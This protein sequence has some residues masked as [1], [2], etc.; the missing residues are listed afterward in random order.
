[1]VEKASKKQPAEPR[2]KLWEVSPLTVREEV[3]QAV[4]RAVATPEKTSLDTELK[5]MKL[6]Q[7]RKLQEDHEMNQLKVIVEEER[8]NVAE[9]TGRRK[10]LEAQKR[11]AG[12]Q[13]QQADT[14]QPPVGFTM[15]DVVELSKLPPDQKAD[16]FKVLMMMKPSG[17]DNGY[18]ILPLLLSSYGQQNPKAGIEEMLAFARAI[19]EAAKNMVNQNNQPPMSND[20]IDKVITL[21]KE[22]KQNQPAPQPGI[23]D[24]IFGNETTY[25]RIKD[26]FGGGKHDAEASANSS[27][28]KL[29]IE[30]QFEIDSR[31]LDQE[32]ELKKAEID[33]EM[34]KADAFGNGVIRLVKAAGT[35]LAQGEAEVDQA[36]S[37]EETRRT[38][39][40]QDTRA[41]GINQIPCP[42]PGCG[43]MIVVQNPKPGQDIKCAKCGSI[44]EWQPNNNDNSNNSQED[45]TGG[46][47]A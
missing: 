19:N 35:A 16:A 14:S 37:P 21:A 41:L 4:D 30:K 40:S 28:E 18:G 29:R 15:A 8:I 3:N 6:D 31:K 43:A 2:K 1:M 36:R 39:S 7:I 25:N 23:F 33:V 24:Q 26:I 34:K 11:G 47:G 44:Y 38:P 42:T 5:R 32:A 27:I 17:G 9:L 45:Q 20:M 46:D 22:S 12:Q 13:T 10:E